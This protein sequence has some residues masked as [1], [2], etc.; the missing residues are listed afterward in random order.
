MCYKENS[1]YVA[2]PEAVSLDKD[3]VVR[4]LRKLKGL[5]GLFVHLSRNRDSRGSAREELNRIGELRLERLAMNEDTA[6]VST[7]DELES[8]PEE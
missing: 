3:K 1:W 5:R 2:E 7:E 4:R 8:E 6:N